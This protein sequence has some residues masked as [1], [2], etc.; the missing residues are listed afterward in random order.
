MSAS[1]RASPLPHLYADILWNAVE[2]G[3]GLAR[4]EARTGNYVAGRIAL[5]NACNEYPNRGAKASARAV[6][7]PRSSA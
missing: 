7:A 1:S 6:S 5:I 2:C 4:E 3:S